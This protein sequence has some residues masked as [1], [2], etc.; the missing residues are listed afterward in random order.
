MVPDFDPAEVADFVAE[1]LENLLDVPVEFVRAA[2][3]STLTELGGVARLALALAAL[4]SEKL[5]ALHTA[6]TRVGAA[7]QG[8]GRAPSTRPAGRACREGGLGA[9]QRVE[10]EIAPRV[11]AATS[12]ARLPS[13]PSSARRSTASSTRCS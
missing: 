2:R 1:R 8:R 3:G 6:Y 10:A 9:L 5:E 12:R 4:D 13:A 11:E 7:R